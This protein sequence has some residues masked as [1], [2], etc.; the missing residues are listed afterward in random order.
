MVSRLFCLLLLLITPMVQSAESVQ[1]EAAEDLAPE[2]LVTQQLMAFI[3][4]WAG[5]WQAQL[6][7]LYI[8]HYTLDYVAPGYPSRQAWLEDRRERLVEPD[9]IRLRLLDFEMV[10][11]TEEHAVTR[12]TLIYERPGYSDETLKE[13]VFTNNNGLWLISEENNLGVNPL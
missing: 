4:D 7:D 1:D 11:L 12:F 10:S 9:F 13:L 6:P 5:T 3:S 8:S 2:D